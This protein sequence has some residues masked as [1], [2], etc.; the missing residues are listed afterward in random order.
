VRVT[1]DAP[2]NSLIIQASAE[3]YATLAEVIEA[4]DTRR[5]QVMVEALIME[6]NANP[7]NTLGSAFI[8][9]MASGDGSTLGV[10]SGNL[11]SSAD[12]ANTTGLA[13]GGASAAGFVT[14][15][16]GV[17]ENVFEDDDRVCPPA[18]SLAMFEFSYG[19][20]K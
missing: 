10:G 5:P 13:T 15:F 17:P 12:F 14:A 2:T 7:A 6:V 18:P 20:A 9:T 8:T 1:A 4:L 19:L 3:A 16:L 11:A